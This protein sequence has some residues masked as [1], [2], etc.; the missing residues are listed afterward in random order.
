MTTP[1]S[2][3]PEIR[4]ALRDGFSALASGNH[5]QAAKVGSQ[6]AARYPQE[7]SVWHLSGV[8]ELSRSNIKQATTLLERALALDPSDV[9][10]HLDY[11]RCCLAAGSR[12][13]ALSS[14]DRAA[15]LGIEST[16]L[17][18]A[19][20]VLYGMCED[21]EKS[22]PFLERAV[23]IDPQPEYLYNLGAAQRMLGDIAGAEDSFS[24]VIAMNPLN[25]R[26][27]FL[28]SNLRKYTPEDHHTEELEHLLKD[29]KVNWRGEVLLH[30]AAGKEYED[31]GNYKA[32]FAHVRAG[33]QIKRRNTQYTVDKD[34]QVIDR[35]IEKLDRRGKPLGASSDEPIFIMG[36]PRSGTTLV[37]R[38]VGN[39]S[40]VIALGE[41]SIFGLE[42][43][44]AIKKTTNKQLKQLDLIDRSLDVDFRRLG[45][46]YLSKA[47]LRNMKQRKFIDKMP[48]N[49][50]YCGLIHATFPNSKMIVLRRNP[51][52]S[53]YAMFK[54]NFE[55]AY[56]FSY[57]LED[58]GKYYI[59]F[60][61]LIEHWKR[62]LG[63]EIYE[64][65]YEDLIANQES[66]TRRL[67]DFCGLDWEDA[68]LDFHENNAA[69]STA[70]A[71]QV[72]QPI[73]NS[74]VDL[75]RNFE[76]ELQPLADI[77]RRGG[78]EF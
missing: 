26:T 12:N 10:Y 65:Q 31:I 51:M 21:Q 47:R 16:K 18:N 69:S 67:I 30:Y 38:I 68:C 13:D 48:M 33:A 22:A 29:G 24:R 39:H 37:E 15:R 58:L 9:A 32:S 25:C 44:D 43:Q 60:H 3:N 42:L 78:I 61:R 66:Q 4:A 57:D 50:L 59:A 35:I 46:V 20:G 73:Y 62:V 34:L 55:G 11:A 77:L 5:D 7:P 40:D 28:R 27:H 2:S 17:L 52:A 70:S 1:P 76:D 54:M 49:Y 45:E 64:I 71:L 23:K 63:D 75:W 74:S 14:L 72:R 53:C 6:L 41:L 56:P 36:L 8:A 19:I